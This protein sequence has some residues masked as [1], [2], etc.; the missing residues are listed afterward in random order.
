M[1]FLTIA[2]IIAGLALIYVI[3]CYF[4]AGFIIHQN[5]QPVPKNPGDYSMSFEN[6]EFKT[7]D[8]VDIKGWLIP[9]KLNKLIVMTHVA[10]LTK[11][12][13]TVSYKNITKLYNKEIEFLKTAE[14]LHKE[15]YGVLM[16]DFR[17][18]GESGPDPNNGI[19]S[20]GLKEYRD[21]V[22]AMDFI[23]HRDDLKNANVGFVS[24]C[25]G[26][27]STIIAMS[28]NPEAFSMVKCIFAVQPI[29]MEVFVRTYI[30][31]FI[32][33]AGASLLMPMI[34]KWVIWRGAYPLG[35]MSPLEYVKDIKVPT[36]YVQARNDPWTR[37]SDIQSFDENTP[38]N[39]KELYYI[40]GT[41]HRFESY[42]Y[43]ANK[44]EI[45]L[46]WLKK[47]V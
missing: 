2:I 37:L 19:A 34:K 16:F 31:K 3:L 30:E 12:G 33:P 11:Y 1:I 40:E 36:M 45:M 24:F 7:S 41:K 25:M 21:V 44:P 22:A 27:N 43:F 5:H 46:E 15:G 28:K 23:S 14:H 10:G 4:I 39:P 35:K 17:N 42:N 9:G 29:S 8:N 47:W 20:I 13:S 6:I 38:D 26:A 32:T 18:H